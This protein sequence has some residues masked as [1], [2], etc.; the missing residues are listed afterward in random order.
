MGYHKEFALGTAT[1]LEGLLKEA[2][3]ND[4]LRRIQAVYF[5]AR[6]NY[7]A[8]QIA[9]MTGYSVRTVRNI[10]S[11]FLRDGCK[12]FD[13]KRPGGRRAAYMP[14][15][16]EAA[17]LLPF[18]EEGDAGGILVVSKIHKALCAHIGKKV[19][20]STAY[21]ILHRH[22]WRKIMPKPRHPKADKEAQADFKKMD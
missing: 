2:R 9:E 15:E 1:L 12:T 16:E 10:H 8:S 21:D 13:L 20:L 6:H 3:N 17:F 11:A 18:I 5:R 22:G 4:A 19:A 7:P 14:P